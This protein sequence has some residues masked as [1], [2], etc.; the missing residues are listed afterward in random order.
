MQYRVVINVTLGALLIISA[1]ACSNNDDSPSS[2]G[3]R[4][5]SSVS[6]GG[7]SDSGGG[8]TLQKRCEEACIQPQAGPCATGD[9]AACIAECV[10]LVD[11]LGAECTDCVL[12]RTG[13]FGRECTC[14]GAQCC[15]TVFGP[16]VDPQPNCNE[17]VN[18]QEEDWA[19]Q[20]MG[21]VLGKP[22][23]MTCMGVCKSSVIDGGAELT[24]T[25]VCLNTVEALARAHERCGGE[26]Q[27]AYDMWLVDLEC[28]KATGLRDMDE[29]LALC[30]PSIQT[31]DC[32]EVIEGIYHAAC[33]RQF[34]YE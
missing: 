33:D 27:V 34:K 24:P 4:D 30:L 32:L 12:Q 2:D 21:H 28:D 16:G 23:S 18:C 14:E 6:E 7:A 22:A 20:C 1:S 17:L 13:W 3:G 15:S 8:A 19:T 25:Q 9:G 11:G 5:T 29:L 26:Y 10:A 31:A